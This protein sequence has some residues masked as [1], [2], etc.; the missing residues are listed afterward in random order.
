MGARAAV[1]DR[2]A[3]ELVLVVADGRVGVARYGLVNCVR[4][5]PV[6]LDQCSLR[7]VEVEALVEVHRTRRRLWS[8]SKNARNHAQ[9]NRTIAGVAVGEP[10]RAVGLGPSPAYSAAPAAR[11]A[12]S[13]SVPSRSTPSTVHRVDLGEAGIA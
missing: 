5:M 11:N 2:H 10:D 6:T 9:K 3:A 1:A 12:C 4:W 13:A 8:T 7:R